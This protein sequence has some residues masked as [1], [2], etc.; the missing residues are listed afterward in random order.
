MCT[1]VEVIKKKL[2]GILV[3]IKILMVCYDVLLSNDGK[4]NKISSI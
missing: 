2:S 1:E 4:L 3:Y